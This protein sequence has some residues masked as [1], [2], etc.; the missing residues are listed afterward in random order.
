MPTQTKPADA[1]LVACALALADRAAAATMPN[2]RKPMS[3]DNKDGNGGFDPVTA[4]DRAA[5]QAIAAHLA[6]AYPDHGLEGE[7][8]ASPN[9]TPATAGSSIPSMAPAPSSRAPPCGGHS[10]AFSMVP[11]P[12]S[13]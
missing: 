10:L 8:S 4:A 11:T 6:K 9:P 1:A 2:F 13:G 3:V 5:E 12:L 7:S